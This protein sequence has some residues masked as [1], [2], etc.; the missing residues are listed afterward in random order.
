MS[1]SLSMCEVLKPPLLSSRHI[2]YISRHRRLRIRSPFPLRT[3]SLLYTCFCSHTTSSGFPRFHFVSKNSSCL[4][5]HLHRYVRSAS[6][7][8]DSAASAHTQP[9]DISIL[10]VPY[11]PLMNA[12]ALVSVPVQPT[13][14]QKVRPL[15]SLSVH[16]LLDPGRHRA[17]FLSV[18]KLLNVSTGVTAVGLPFELSQV[19]HIA[20]LDAR[21]SH[22]VQ[23]FPFLT[24]LGVAPGRSFVPQ[25]FIFLP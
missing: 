11:Y 9:N 12:L 20:H 1:S 18:L 2:S 6:A 8:V 19:E 4:S 16:H 10:T 3:S 25:F 7:F 14:G 24:L 13:C 23:A 21:T 22:H 17:C 5:L 15:P